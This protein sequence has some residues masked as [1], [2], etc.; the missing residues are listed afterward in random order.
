VSQRT[1]MWHYVGP[2]KYLVQVPGTIS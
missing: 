1:V 2:Y